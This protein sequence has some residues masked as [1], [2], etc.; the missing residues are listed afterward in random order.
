M[1]EHISA[2]TGRDRIR[3]GDLWLERI[4]KIGCSDKQT[5]NRKQT[6]NASCS[7]DREEPKSNIGYETKPQ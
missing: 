3:L 4:Y 6:L 5:K 1:L 7:I 2:R